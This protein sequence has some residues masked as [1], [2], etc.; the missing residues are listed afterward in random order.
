MLWERVLQHHLPH[1][2]VRQ[3]LVR[4]WLWILLRY[5]PPPQFFYL[6]FNVIFVWTLLNVSVPWKGS[7]VDEFVSTNTQYTPVSDVAVNGWGNGYTLFLS[8][9]VAINDG[10]TLTLTNSGCPSSMVHDHLICYSNG[11][12]YNTFFSSLDCGN[13]DYSGGGWNSGQQYGYGTFSL[14]GQSTNVP[15]K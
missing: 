5:F 1:L 9:N 3:W 15:G 7:F 11:K 2:P 10:L 12:I 14:T 8:G 13:L 4:F 6:S